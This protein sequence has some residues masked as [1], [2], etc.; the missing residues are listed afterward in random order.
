MPGA[1][2]HRSALRRRRVRRVELLRD[3]R[4][5]THRGELELH[6]QPIADLADGTLRA[7]E[8]LVRWRHPERGLLGPGQFIARAE[9]TGA[10]RELGRFVLDGACRTAADWT[11]A[12]ARAASVSV[13][14]SGAQL[15]DARFV[16]DVA[17]ALR[18]NDLPA[19]RLALEVTESVVIEPDPQ[20][21]ATLR[22][23]RRL[24]VTLALDDFGTGFCR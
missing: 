3:L 15:G 11:S 5:A 7:A 14:V 1:G 13:S 10:I 24:G 9:E 21:L 22:E 20:T 23:L 2:R 8:A 19:E 16:T 6:F 12:A 18:R 4:G 17:A